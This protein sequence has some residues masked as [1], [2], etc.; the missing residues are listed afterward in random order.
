MGPD[1]ILLR[2]L[3]VALMVVGVFAF[4]SGLPTAREWPVILGLII[5]IVICS[6]GALWLGA[7]WFE[8]NV[9]P[10]GKCGP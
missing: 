1:V 4:R 2:L 6:L 3:V 5:L 9:C 8:N 7:L 10:G